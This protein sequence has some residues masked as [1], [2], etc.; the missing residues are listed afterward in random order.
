MKLNKHININ[1]KLAEFV[2]LSKAHSVLI[3]RSTGNVLYP[4][5]VMYVFR[6]DFRLFC[7]VF[8]HKITV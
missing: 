5:W 3:Y 7:N 8:R 6:Y 4:I 2:F 1:V